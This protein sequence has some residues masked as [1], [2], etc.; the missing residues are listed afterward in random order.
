VGEALG[1]LELYS[2]TR[3]GAIDLSSWKFNIE[4]WCNFASACSYLYKLGLKKFP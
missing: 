2:P 3:D 1:P 4:S